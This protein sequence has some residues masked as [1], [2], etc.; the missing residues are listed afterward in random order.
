[1]ATIELHDGRGRVEF[2]TIARE[3]PVL[4]GSDPKC[5][6]VLDDPSILPFHGRLRWRGDRFKAEAFPEARALDL[7]GKQV[8]SSSFRVGDE[9]A[10]GRFKLFLSDDGGAGDLE[11]TRVQE[12]PAAAAAGGVEAAWMGASEAAGAGAGGAPA[13]ARGLRRQAAPAGAPAAKAGAGASDAGTTVKPVKVSWWRKALRKL[14]AGTAAPG[15][16]DLSKSPLILGLGVALLTLLLLAYVLWNIFAENRARM[17]FDS[18]KAAFQEFRYGD[19]KKLFTDYLATNPGHEHASEARVLRA[20]SNVRE[21]TA[22]GG[23]SW[24]AAMENAEA[25]VKDYGDEPAYAEYRMQL[26]QDVLKIAEGFADQAKAGA[27]AKALAAAEAATKFHEKVSDAAHKSLISK[28]NLPKKMVEAQAAVTKA[29]VRRDAV[30]AMAEAIAARTPEPVFLKRDELVNRYPDLEADKDVVKHL[31]DANE[32]I[33]RAVTYDPT[34]RPAETEPRPEPLGP[35]VSLVLR[36]VPIGGSPQPPTPDGPLVYAMVQGYAYALDGSNGAPVWH[37]PLGLTSPFAP[38]AISGS[39]PSVLAFD[40]RNDELV[41]L[42]GR[43][44]QLVWRQALGE[45][46][47]SP[48][49]VL[50]NQALQVL[51][52]GKLLALDLSTGAVKGTLTIG[53]PLAGTPATDEAGQYFYVTGDRDS[54]YVISRD[55]VECVSVTYLGHPPGS[56]KCAPARLANFLIVPQN[57]DLW[58]GKWSIFVLDQQGEAPRLVQTVPTTGWTWQTPA[59]QGTILWSITD[60][61]SLTAYAMG[62]ED[63]KEPLT[64]VAA[65]V[66]DNRPSGPAFASARGDR[67]LWFSGSRIGRFDLEPETG[68]LTPSWTIERAGQAVGPIQQAGRLAVFSHQYDDGAG[69]ALWAVDP[70]N[71]QVAWRTVLGAPWPLPPTP[72][73]DGQELTTLA[74]DG[75]KATITRDQLERGGFLEW[76]LPRPGYF[77]LP[78]GPLQRLEKGDLTVLVPAP[79]A[80]HLLVRQGAEADF[81]RVDLPAPLG[82]KPVFWDDALFVPG[83]D[84]RAYLV[85]PKTGAPEAEPYVPTFDADKPTRWRDPVFLAGGVVLVDESGKVRRLQKVTEP[86]LRLDVVGEAMDLKSR[87]PADPA[88]TGDALIVVTEDKKV[89]SLSGRDLSSLGAWNLDVP[90]AVGPLAVGQEVLLVDKAGGVQAFSPDGS[91][92]WAQD[93]RDDPPL[94]RPAVLGDGVWLLGRDGVLQQRSAADGSLIDR[95]DLGILPGGGLS[96]VGGDVVVEAAPGTLRVLR[97]GAAGAEASASSGTQ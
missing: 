35:P 47:A 90:A 28:S 8:V 63:A 67:E 13:T 50:G 41:R 20:L 21:F 71:G 64:R 42:D 14:N 48:P 55:P 73:P 74:M 25:M 95:V 11:P 82:A 81:R 89:R 2:V 88:S 37:V 38:V 80:D 26:A 44:G 29:Q 4:F 23:V 32:L 9:I 72:G 40:A 53:R 18:A 65:T 7:N 77:S 91:R 70:T 3:N 92:L 87:V 43:T 84:G 46:I 30:D 52:S 10:V 83:L 54:L 58:A 6:I 1:M 59:S 56:I 19:A 51:P 94:G 24:T 12:R 79:D 49:L 97:P 15:E 61:N 36:Q 39:K 60:R 62:P 93:L 69:V 76:P 96:G 34:G 27:D 68:S 5:D 66:A 85:D 33:R 45:P 86:R 78:K 17:Q 31:T 22:A 57:G 16:E 75:P